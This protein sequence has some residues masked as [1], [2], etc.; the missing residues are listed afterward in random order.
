MVISDRDEKFIG[1][2]WMDLFKGLGTQLDFSTAYHPQN[3][4][5]TERVNH[6]LE[7]MHRM[8]VMGKI[9]M[10]EQ[11]FSFGGICV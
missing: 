11:N 4:M 1:N 9:G 3:D 2:F 6:I 7:Y 5:K 10:W 8:Y